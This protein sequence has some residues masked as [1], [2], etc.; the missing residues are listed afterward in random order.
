M[1][2]T[3]GQRSLPRHISPCRQSVGAEVRCLHLSIHVS[4]TILRATMQL[5]CRL[6]SLSSLVLS[7]VISH[8]SA[9]SL[10]DARSPLPNPIK[11]VLEYSPA[12][13]PHT[14]C[15]KVIPPNTGSNNSCFSR[16]ST[17]NKTQTVQIEYRSDYLNPV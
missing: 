15:T 10:F 16:K 1:A 6:A 14:E 17:K 5:T 4:P 3:A 11:R 8:V 9:D 2:L 7:I 12:I 13:S